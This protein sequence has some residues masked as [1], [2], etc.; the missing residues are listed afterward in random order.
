MLLDFTPFNCADWPSN[1]AP[2]YGMLK[3]N[4]S[5]AMGPLAAGNVP[6]ALGNI[7]RESV[8][9]VM[10]LSESNVRGLQFAKLS[11]QAHAGWACVEIGN[12]NVGI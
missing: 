4:H 2:R 3:R 1:P 10:Q 5:E 11:R 9:F 8:V 6:I 12:C 7:R